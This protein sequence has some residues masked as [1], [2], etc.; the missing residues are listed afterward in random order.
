MRE[1]NSESQ[2]QGRKRFNYIVKTLTI[3]LLFI[4][5][6]QRIY[7]SDRS[8]SPRHRLK[9]MLLTQPLPALSAN[10]QLPDR[11]PEQAWRGWVSG[12]GESHLC[13]TMA[14]ATRPLL[15]CIL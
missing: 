3:L 5:G 12:D 9:K 8:Y 2:K 7:I 13:K 6:S 10:T 4:Y 15:Y 1:Y 14:G 11:L